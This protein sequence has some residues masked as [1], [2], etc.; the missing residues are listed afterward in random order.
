L[1]L[2]LAV[3]GFFRTGLI[4]PGRVTAAG[5]QAEPGRTVQAARE[6]IVEKYEAVGTVRPRIETTI[7]AQVTGRVMDV[8]VNP[9][10]TV[11]KGDELVLLDSRSLQAQLE[12]A[13]EGLKQAQAKW[14]QAEQAVVGATAEYVKARSDFQRY[15]ELYSTMA[16]TI[17]E[18]EQAKAG[19]LAAEAAMKKAHQGL[20]EAEAAVRQAQKAVEEAEVALTYTTMTA[21]EPAQVVKRLVD[22]GDLAWPGKPLLTLQT[23]E[24]LRLEALVREGLIDRVRPGTELPVRLDSLNKTVSGMVEELVPSADPQTRTFLVKVVLEAAPGL[25]PGMFGRLLVPLTEEEVVAVPAEAVRR[26]GQ[27]EMVRVRENDGWRSQFV[28]IGR[29]VG[30]KIEILSGLNGTETIALPEEAEAEAP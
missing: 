5:D 29:R 23:S 22:P 8:L 27:L 21:L 15:K 18:K 2:I 7:E 12:Q 3:G 14:R 20:T 10:D 17:Q 4:T 9:G 6:T 24:S 13:R 19:Y 25:F 28:R 11:D 26:V 1:A 30:D 16:A